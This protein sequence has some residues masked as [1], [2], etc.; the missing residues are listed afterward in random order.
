V[1]SGSLPVRVLRWVGWLLGS[2]HLACSLLMLMLVVVVI[3]TLQQRVM[4]LY[5]VQETYFFALAFVVRLGPVPI[6]WPG[7]S[8]LLGLLLVNL[9]VGGVVR[10]RKGTS[11]LG[12]LISHLGIVLLLVGSFIEWTASSKGSMHLFEGESSD[13]FESYEHW[14]LSIFDVASPKEYVI[15][16]AALAQAADGRARRFTSPDLPFD[17]VASGWARNATPEKSPSRDVGAEGYRI[18]ALA[19][20]RKQAEAN[21]PGLYVTVAPHDGSAPV[22]TILLGRESGRPFTPF[23]AAIGGKTWVVELQRQRWRLPFRIELTKT[24]SREH[25]GSDIPSEYSSYVRKIEDGVA[26]D[27]HITMNEPLRH[28]G[29]T[30][31]QS[32]FRKA[33]DG[34]PAFSG[35]AV[36]RNPT[37]RV[38]LVACIVIAV[39]LLMHFVRKLIRHLDVQAARRTSRPSGDTEPSAAEARA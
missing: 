30:F 25:P 31:Y 24:V 22:R 13:Q 1:T 37:D 16:D 36:V 7:G 23:S 11:T 5:D 39:G 10:M 17:V 27:V 35:L 9:L 4:S 28:R 21:R 15:P 20:D 14:E 2:F 19:P 29:Y 32:N 3:G 18:R 12:I 38:P 8:L 6:P 26:Q 34:R 33:E